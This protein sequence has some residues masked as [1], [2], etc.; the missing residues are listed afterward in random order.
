MQFSRTI[1]LQRIDVFPIRASG[2]VSPKMALGTM[3]T[4]PALLVRI[5][6]SQGCF[7]WGEVW[8]NFPPRANIHKAHI[9]QDV[10]ADHLKDLRFT[11]PREVGEALRDRLSVFFLH[12][13]QVQ[14]FEHILAGIDT[15]VW[16]L[17]LRSA[18]VCFAD[19]MALPNAA[20]R[21]YATSIN[22]SDLERLIPLHADMG[23]TFFKLK[24]GF[25]EHG[26]SEIVGRAAILSPNGARVMVDS[27]QSWTLEQAIASL[28]QI[29]SYDPYFAEE[30]LRA[31]APKSDWEA[32]AKQTRIPLAGG[33]N[34]YGIDEF[35]AMT[36]VGM[37][38]LQP[39]VAKWGGVSG[40]LDLAK[41]VPDGTMIW[42]HFM[43]TAIGQVASLSISAALG[44]MSYC[45]VDVNANALRTDLCG[46][47]IAIKEGCVALPQ[48]PGLIVPPVP[49]CLTQFADRVA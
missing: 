9:I 8:A 19:F 37:K 39:D 23:Q 6:D 14:V 31:D 44:D 10:V 2:G 13:G 21:S 16:D 41:S 5:E 43:G 42:P 22:A 25:A 35:L 27:N 40:A 47:V 28:H 15:A 7:G 34:I 26:N 17:A 20:A 49:E 38:V 29:E 33:E 1:T 11:D 46:D 24:I 4:R 32:L 12:V 48:E 36:D 30:A 45:E 3:P 18:G